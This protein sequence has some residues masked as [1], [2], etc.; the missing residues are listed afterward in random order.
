MSRAAGRQLNQRDQ[1]PQKTAQ[2]TFAAKTYLNQ[3]FNR[4]IQPLQ[5]IPV[6]FPYR[7]N[8]K[9]VDKSFILGLFSIQS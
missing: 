8:K 3:I 1:R 7:K 6:R 4:N 5:I 9:V 2:H